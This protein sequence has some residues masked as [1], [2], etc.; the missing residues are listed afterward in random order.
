[1]D[2]D[3]ELEIKHKGKEE[4]KED[5]K[6]ADTKKADAAKKAD[7]KKADAKKADDDDDDDDDKKDDAA[8][9]DAV[10]A[11]AAEL[12]RRIDE[13][14]ETIRRLESMMK[15][16]SDEEHAAFAEAQAKADAVYNGFGLRAPRPLDGEVLLDYRKRLATKL[17][18]YSPNWQNTKFRKLDEE[19]FN[20]IESQVYS[21]AAKAATT[22]LDLNP[23]ELRKVEKRTPHGGTMIEFYG[24]ESFVKQMGRPGRRVA[25][26]RTLGSQ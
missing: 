10:K 26:F 14:S 1:M 7:A 3:G 2:D 11:D 17:K 12:R 16:R 8:K 20:T 15:P 25:A 6:K 24:K 5:S 23:G 18:S 13:Q 4:G 21:D 9:D 19:T 22:P